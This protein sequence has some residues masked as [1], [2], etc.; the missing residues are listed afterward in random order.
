MRTIGVELLVAMILQRNTPLLRQPGDHR[1]MDGG[2]DRIARDDRQHIMERD[3]RLLEC[4]QIIERQA[5]RLERVGQLTNLIIARVLSRVAGETDLEEGA[6][7]LEVPNA[8][9]RGEKMPR[10]AGQRLDNGGR[11]WLRDS[12]TFAAVDRDQAH[13][14][15]R[16]Q[17]L[18]HS[19]PADAG[20]LHQLA[21]GR[22]LISGQIVPVMNH[23]LDAPGDLLIELAAADRPGS[24][25]Y[26]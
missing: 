24:C 10:R 23:R 16:E 22:Q 19:W 13:L 6:R 3:I 8:I 26:T 12:G 7:L 20:L 9:R 17:R 11:C 2:E 1:L 14:L 5:V 18:T 4:A 21:L 25:W 15:Q